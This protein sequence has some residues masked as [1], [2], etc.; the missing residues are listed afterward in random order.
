M[1]TPK[2]VYRKRS[3][4]RAFFKSQ[5][6]TYIP[7]TR[8][9][10]RPLL[11]VDLSVSEYY[12]ENRE[13]FDALSRQYGPSIEKGEMAP[14][15]IMKIDDNVGYG[16]FAAQDIPADAFIGEYAGVVQEEDEDTGS[17]MDHGGYESDYSWYYLDDIEGLP[18]LEI[19]GRLEGN[20]MRFV[21]HGPSPNIA[22]EHTLHHGQWII[23]FRAARDIGKDEQLLI[24]YGSAYWDDGYRELADVDG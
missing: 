16:V 8:I 1:P 15:Y 23:F 9:A 17:E 13:E 12:Q 21:N 6:I 10:Y 14:V 19:N 24:D 5:G 4:V 18:T 2:E 11:D 3:E 22:V 7:H 20:E